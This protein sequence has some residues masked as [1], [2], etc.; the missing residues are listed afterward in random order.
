MKKIYKKQRSKCI[1]I[2]KKS[3]RNYFNKIANRNIVTNRTF[4]KI[5]K[6]FLSNKGHLENVDI[7][8]NDNNKIVCNDHKLVEVFNEDYINIIEKS[9]GETP[10]NITEGYSFDNDKQAIKIICNS[11]KNNPSILKIR[12]AITVI[13]MITQFFRL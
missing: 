2:R 7:M 6:P 11:Y 8:L 4:W 5:I 1:A 10:T 13:V 3:I 9:S 12:S